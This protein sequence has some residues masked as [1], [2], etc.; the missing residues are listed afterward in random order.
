MKVLLIEDETQ[1][2]D[3]VTAALNDLPFEITIELRRSYQSGLKFFE[4]GVTVDCI[5]LD[6]SLPTFDATMNTRHGRP[7][8]LGGYDLMRKLRRSGNKSPVIVLTAYEN[9][10]LLDEQLTFDELGDVLRS[11]FGYQFVDIIY[12]SQSRSSWYAQLHNSLTELSK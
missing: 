3:R 1:K 5:I 10:G 2:A 6:M 8:P 9:F 11:E 12:Y 4:N 7:R